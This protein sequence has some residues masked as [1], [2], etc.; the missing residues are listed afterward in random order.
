MSTQAPLAPAPTT[1]G[2]SG[3]VRT[4]RHLPRF[5]AAGIFLAGVV[6]ARC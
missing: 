4:Q 1:G 6:L 3:P 5:A 2:A